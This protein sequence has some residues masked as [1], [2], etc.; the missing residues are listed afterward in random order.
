MEEGN[1]LESG[2]VC[3]GWLRN[4]AD[5]SN[6]LWEEPDPRYKKLCNCCRGVQREDVE[7]LLIRDVVANVKCIPCNKIHSK[8]QH[9]GL[10]LFRCAAGRGS[11]KSSCRFRD[12]LQ[13]SRQGCF[14]GIEATLGC[15]SDTM[16]GGD[17]RIQATSTVS[18]VLTYYMVQSR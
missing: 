13:K 1:F 12:W 18:T 14:L 8:K 11:L 3:L 4:W 9:V 7:H 15:P 6:P 17:P 10:W 2:H 5:T 16:P